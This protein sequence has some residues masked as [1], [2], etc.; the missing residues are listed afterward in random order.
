MRFFTGNNPIPEILR[1]AHSLL[2]IDSNNSSLS[3]PYR[4]FPGTRN[5]AGVHDHSHTHHPKH[6]A[7]FSRHFSNAIS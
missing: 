6:I 7:D 3:A 1:N 2:G 5:K 4:H